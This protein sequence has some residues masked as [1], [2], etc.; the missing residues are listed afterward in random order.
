MTQ[1]RC[2][3]NQFLYILLLNLP[4]SIHIAEIIPSCISKI[5]LFIY[6]SV[7]GPFLV[8]LP[9]FVIPFLLPLATERMLPPPGPFLGSLSLSRIKCIF[10]H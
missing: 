7:V 2:Y 3:K 4:L 8:T 6:I 5:I 9:Q 1:H 10:S